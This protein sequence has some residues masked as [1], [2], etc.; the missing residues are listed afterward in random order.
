[1][2][3]TQ[4]FEFPIKPRTGSDLRKIYTSFLPFNPDSSIK[5]ESKL[6]TMLASNSNMPNNLQTNAFAQASA[7]APGSPQMIQYSYTS[8]SMDGA[9]AKKTKLPIPRF[10]EIRPA[11]LGAW[12]G[13][14]YLHIYASMY[15]ADML[16]MTLDHFTSPKIDP[17]IDKKTGKLKLPEVK[18]TENSDAVEAF[19]KGKEDSLEYRLALTRIANASKLLK[20]IEKDAVLDRAELR[21]YIAY[22]LSP[23]YQSYRADFLA[24]VR[25]GNPAWAMIDTGALPIVLNFA[26][27]R[28]ITNAVRTELN[29]KDVM[30]EA[31]ISATG[32]S[33]GGEVYKYWIEDPTGK[34]NVMTEEERKVAR[35]ATLL[36]EKYVEADAIA[37]DI[38]MEHA[39][40]SG[41][42]H[43]PDEPKLKEL[44]W[45]LYQQMN[46]HIP[47]AQHGGTGSSRIVKG[48]VAK[49]NVNTQYLYEGA[50]AELQRCKKLGSDIEKRVKDA[51]GTE[52]FIEEIA[53][54]RKCC[55]DYLKATGTLGLSPKFREILSV[56]A[57][58]LTEYKAFDI[59]AT[60]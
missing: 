20:P 34:G 2:A 49:Y 37:Y 9:D 22:M 21:K 7:V 5:P 3:L 31:E 14:L 58:A 19:L 1:M 32:Q 59:K 57:P 36:F 33:G 56:Q 55:L 53:A 16:F 38:G 51:V 13:N 23:E 44:Q 52:R 27:S 42:I 46:R 12:L 29:N 4:P 54:V 11:G 41:E 40:K 8:T 18:A 30:L 10:T 15:G 17:E 39:A 48:L 47:F 45:L 28:D 6:L 35:A 50:N 25:F 60:E 26:T 24:A 43:E